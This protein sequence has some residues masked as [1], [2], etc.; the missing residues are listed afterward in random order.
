MALSLG[1][2]LMIVTARP[3][4]GRDNKPDMRSLSDTLSLKVRSALLIVMALL[5]TTATSAD[6][7]KAGLSAAC[8][9]SF[10]ALADAPGPDGRDALIRLAGEA[11]A[12]DR[13]GAALR[14][15]ERG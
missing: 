5:V 7:P 15:A 14:S 9:K 8:K 12:L 6:E 13:V 10:R 1:R 3:R 2:R 4:R 11:L